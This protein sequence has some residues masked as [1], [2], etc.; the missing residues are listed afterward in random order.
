MGTIYIF[1]KKLDKSLFQHNLADETK[2]APQTNANRLL[3]TN[4]PILLKI[5]KG[6][7]LTSYGYFY[8]KRKSTG[9]EKKLHHKLMQIDCS[10]QIIL[11]Y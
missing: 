7:G 3:D 9:V 11:Y 5:Q 4:H 8:G 2:I 1:H 10:T 6:H